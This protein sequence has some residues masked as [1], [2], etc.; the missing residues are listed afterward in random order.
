MY[1]LRDVRGFVPLPTAAQAAVMATVASPARPTHFL[2]A[3]HFSQVSSGFMDRASVRWALASQERPGHGWRPH[4]DGI[5]ENLQA[6]PRARLVSCLVHVSDVGSLVRAWDSVGARPDV[7]FTLGEGRGDCHGTIEGGARI[8]KDEAGH[9]VIDVT[10]SRPGFLVVA[11]TW[12]PGWV[13]SVSGSVAAIHR[14]EGVFRAVPV[15][16]GSHVVEMTYAPHG[17][18]WGG[19]LSIVGLIL[20]VVLVVPGRAPRVLAQTS[21]DG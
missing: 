6:L 11:D 15:S 20:I 2:A 7:A 18:T 9:L 5:Y 19:W 1:G 14:A 12:F 16:S 21:G 3:V 4:A 8:V 10:A 13:A 17:V